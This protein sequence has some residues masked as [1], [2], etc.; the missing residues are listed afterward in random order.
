M[1]VDITLTPSPTTLEETATILAT[2]EATVVAV[3]VDDVTDDYANS[4]NVVAGGAYFGQ[5]CA[6]FLSAVPLETEYD[7]A[8]PFYLEAT[9]AQACA[10][11]DPPCSTCVR[12]D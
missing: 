1:Q 3:V 2:A 5:Q 10:G 7:T 4:G 12:G 6:S 8:N 11:K 9:G